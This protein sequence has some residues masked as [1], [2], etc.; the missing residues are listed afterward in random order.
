[1]LAEEMMEARYGLPSSK[2]RKLVD[3]MVNQCLTSDSETSQ[4]EAFLAIVEGQK[5]DLANRRTVL[6][7]AVLAGLGKQVAGGLLRM[8]G[9]E[10]EAE[11][12]PVSMVSDA[13]LA[14]GVR[15]LL[16]DLTTVD[17]PEEEKREEMVRDKHESGLSGLGI[18]VDDMQ[19]AV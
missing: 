17:V 5:L 9:L 15:G 6:G 16:S 1:M 12:K 14:E 4:R 2:M 11:V 3:V 19:D 10:Q 7:N 18:V 13:D 8:M